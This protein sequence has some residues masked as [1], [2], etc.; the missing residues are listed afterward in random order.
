MKVFLGHGSATQSREAWSPAE[1]SV[2]TKATGIPHEG[3]SPCWIGSLTFALGH[4]ES[5]FERVPTQFS[6]PLPSPAHPQLTE[7]PPFTDSSHFK[8]SLSLLCWGLA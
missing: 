3:S 2:V 7:S 6:A 8:R 4:L 1:F 5:S